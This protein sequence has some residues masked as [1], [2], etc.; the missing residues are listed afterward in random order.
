MLTAQHKSIFPRKGIIYHKIIIAKKI[1]G[2]NNLCK[3][4]YILFMFNYVYLCYTF[5]ITHRFQICHSIR[6]LLLATADHS[7]CLVCLSQ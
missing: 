6:R 7:V 4:N 1:N 5:G 2:L 3:E